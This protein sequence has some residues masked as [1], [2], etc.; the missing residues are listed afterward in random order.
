VGVYFMYEQINKDI[1]EAKGQ[2]RKKERL[3]ALL[4]R[5]KESLY[6]EEE[7][8]SSLKKVLRKEE[9]DVKKLEGMSIRK[10]VYTIL[11]NKEE[12]LS[13][14]QRE[15]LS[16]KL[17]Y[18][19]CRNAVQVLRDEIESYLSQLS[20]LGD[21]HYYLEQLLKKKEELV[22]SS[23][24]KDASKIQENLDKIAQFFIE[25]NEIREAILAGNNAMDAL[26][27]AIEAARAGESGKGFAVVADEIRKLAEQSSAATS[28]IQALIA[29][30]KEKSKL[31]YSTMEDSKI[32]V[33]AQT[34]AVRQTKDIFNKISSSIE[35]IKNETKEIVTSIN[36]TNNQKEQ[37]LD[38]MQS[39][40]SVSEE[41]SA[42]TE[43][44]SAA[45]EEI[46]AA[47]NEFNSTASQLSE[48]VQLLE[49]E[50]NKFKLK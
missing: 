24:D 47:M 14:E 17:K 27:A 42:S 49:R 2:V 21:L 28:N 22:L 37:I 44:V 41:S 4:Q 9:K 3:E 40:S 45:T 7:R 38:T 6:Q 12:K 48:L 39:I 10:L 18:D 11:G 19:E 29:E 31:A 15:F 46:S 36:E 33:E 8:L 26:E 5:A 35:N 30:V 13:K 16:A 25:Q 20:E 32:V 1:A 34:E 43:E 50:I 23:G